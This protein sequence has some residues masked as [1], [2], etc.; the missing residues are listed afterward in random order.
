MTDISCE[1]SDD[2]YVP[3]DSENSETSDSVLSSDGDASFDDGEPI[4][5]EG[6]K[7]VSNIF[8]DNR[9]GAILPLSDEH[10]GVNDAVRSDRF[11]TLGSVFK[12]LFWWWSDVRNMF[13]DKWKSWRI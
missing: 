3:R 5:C 11:T 13:M 4:E 8:T 7:V 1:S 10:V 2:L 6:W 12:R 9:P